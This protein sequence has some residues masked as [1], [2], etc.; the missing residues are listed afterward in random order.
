MLQPFG[1]Q[2]L[3]ADLSKRAR[4]HV[5]LSFDFDQFNFI[6]QFFQLSLNPVAL[7]QSE[8]TGAGTESNGW[9]WHDDWLACRNFSVQ[10][11]ENCSRNLIA[12]LTPIFAL[13]LTLSALFQLKI[14]IGALSGFGDSHGCSEIT[15][16]IATPANPKIEWERRTSLAQVTSDF[17]PAKLIRHQFFQRVNQID[18]GRKT[19][20][21]TH[22]K[23]YPRLHSPVI[24]HQP[25]APPPQQKLRPRRSSSEPSPIR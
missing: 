2:T 22:R 1:K 11:S 8:F 21:T 10:E 23:S 20:Q 25:R 5:T 7:R 24:E 14:R 12:W 4:P 19:Q 13:G 16:A 3:A 15:Q 6:P 18:S 17:N 9:I